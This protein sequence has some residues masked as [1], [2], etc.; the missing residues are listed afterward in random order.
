MRM[1]AKARR[2]IGDL[3]SAFT[4]DSRLL[5]P[6]FQQQAQTDCPRAVSDYIAGMTD[7]YAIKEYRRLFAVE[8]G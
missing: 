5:P 6:Q 8:E 3:F 4:E 7:R 1:S 2:I